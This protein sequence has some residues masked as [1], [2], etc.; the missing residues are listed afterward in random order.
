MEDPRSQNEEPL[1]IDEDLARAERFYTRLRARVVGW[2]RRRGKMGTRAAPYLL[3][4]PDLFALLLRLIRDPRV[5]TGAKLKMLAA[6]AYVI[7]PIDLVP[8]FLLPVGLLDDTVAVALV[9][10]QVMAMLQEAGED[11][12]REHWEGTGD[13][14]RN[15]RLV[16]G[17]AEDLLGGRV[18]KRLHRRFRPGSK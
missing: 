11:I 6:T 13:V 7:S 12:L 18:V 3:L 2:L 9:L 1:S 15:I 16:L 17:A 14:L 8:D 10:S 5:G 4:L